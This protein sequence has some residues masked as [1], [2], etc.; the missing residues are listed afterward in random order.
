[1]TRAFWGINFSSLIKNES[2]R[3]VQ[4]NRG[5]AL[6]LERLVS[7]VAVGLTRHLLCL[8]TFSTDL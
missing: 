8:T 6:R 1:M 5:H 2:L 3:I 7:V 4:W